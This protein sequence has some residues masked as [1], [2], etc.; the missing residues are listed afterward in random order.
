[1]KP[2]IKGT[3]FGW[4]DIDDQRI[5][6]DILIRLNGEVNKRKKKLSKEIY[7]TS[8]TISLAEAEYIYQEGARGLVIGAGQFGRVRLSP[9]AAAFFQ[10]KG[11]PVTILTTPQAVQTWNESQQK[12][13]GLFHITC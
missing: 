3:G 4:I 6:H 2:T 5:S 13:I 10:E 9:E 12:I 7:G 11:C 8:H 1:M